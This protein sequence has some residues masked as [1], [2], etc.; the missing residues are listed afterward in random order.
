MHDMR[1]PFD[2]V[3]LSIVHSLHVHVERVI[4][5]TN[6]KSLDALIENR[7]RHVLLAWFIVLPQVHSSDSFLILAF[8]FNPDVFGMRFVSDHKD[9][10]VDYKPKGN[11]VVTQLKLRSVLKTSEPEDLKLLAFVYCCDEVS[12]IHLIWLEIQNIILHY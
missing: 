8:V 5:L 4:L 1:G 3:E 7:H 12:S 6:D 11:L 9:V 2:L 10:S